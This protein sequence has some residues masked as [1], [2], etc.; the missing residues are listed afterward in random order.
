MVTTMLTFPHGSLQH[1]SQLLLLLMLV[2]LVLLVLH[3]SQL[4]VLLAHHSS[5]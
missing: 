3:L 1:P 4:L 2:L 5:H